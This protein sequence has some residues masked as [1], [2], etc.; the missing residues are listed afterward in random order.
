MCVWGGGR[1]VFSPWRESHF[2]VPN[3]TADSGQSQQK[4]A[5]PHRQTGP[6]GGQGR[7]GRQAARDCRCVTFIT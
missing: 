7:D 1:S 5:Q 3:T 6:T 4:A 2:I